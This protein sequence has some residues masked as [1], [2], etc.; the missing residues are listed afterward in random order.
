VRAFPPEQRSAAL[1]ALGVPA[2]RHREVER[3]LE[4]MLAALTTPA[5]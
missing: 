1:Q 2:A 5:G 4:E 3:A